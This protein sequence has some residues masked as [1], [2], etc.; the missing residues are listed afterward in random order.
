MGSLPRFLRSLQRRLRRRG[1]SPERA[2]D[3]VQEAYLRMALYCKEGRDVREP[4][5]FLTRTVLNLAIDAR[6]RDHLDLYE[7]AP[8]EQFEIRDLAPTPEEVFALEERL[9][10]M[11]TSLGRAGVRTRE[12]FFLHRLHGCTYEEIA[13]RLGVSVS[14]IEKDIASA[15]TLLAME[16][17]E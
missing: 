14:T 2:E 10:R 1:E 5:A 8:V 9:T 15:I 3:L 4:R 11:W 17:Q 7:A 13:R 16:R 12:A 6:R